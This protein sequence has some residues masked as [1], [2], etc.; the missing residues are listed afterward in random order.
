[1]PIRLLIV[2]DHGV[3][4]AGLAALLN[5][6]DDLVVV[7]AAGS[8]QEAVSLA[9]ELK[10]DVVLMDFSM[11]D[12][13]GIEAA[14]KVG[15]VSPISKVLILTVHEEESLV[16]QAVQSGVAGFILKRAEEVELLSAIRAVNQGQLYIHPALTRALVNEAPPVSTLSIPHMEELTPR[17]IEVLKHLAK[18][19][20]N[21][22]IAELLS[23]S[24]RTVEGHRA[25]LVGKLGVHSRVEI[26]EI[27]EKL[28]LLESAG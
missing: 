2:D 13:D 5:D 24:I 11:F 9:A 25:N 28:G 22:Q 17:E 26:M 3:I 27:A 7:G 8:G 15:Q 20:T 16:R 1:M 18:G 21:R 14:R 10:P 23:I 12:M 4:R 6:Q 19:Y